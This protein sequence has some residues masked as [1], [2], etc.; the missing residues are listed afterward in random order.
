[1]FQAD[2]A[3]ESAKETW[4]RLNVMASEGTW[5]LKVAG[6]TAGVAVTVMAFFRYERPVST[7]MSLPQSL[8][9]CVP[10]LQLPP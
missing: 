8:S 5:T 9:R 6:L 3:M 7:I 2:K 1:V 10:L 4:D